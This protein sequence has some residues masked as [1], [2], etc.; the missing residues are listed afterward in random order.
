MLLRPFLSRFSPRTYC[1]LYSLRSVGVLSHILKSGGLTDW[2]FGLH[3][4]DRLLLVVALG[5]PVMPIVN[6]DYLKLVLL[7]VYVNST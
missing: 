5:I 4:F 3:V 6:S 1:I 2:S 7:Y